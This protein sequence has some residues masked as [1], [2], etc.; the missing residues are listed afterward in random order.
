MNPIEVNAEHADMTAHIGNLSICPPVSG[1]YWM[2]RVPVAP[3]QAV[4][5]F[6]K[7]STIGCG[8]QREDDWN[9]NLPLSCDARKIFD[10]IKHNKQCDATDEECIAAIEALQDL[11]SKALPGWA[12]KVA[13]VRRATP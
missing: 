8:F 5:A 13:R 12:E 7:F 11:A 9:T 10:H 1:D 6:K 2:W 4:V 3:D